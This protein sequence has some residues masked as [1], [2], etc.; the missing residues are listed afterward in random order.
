VAFLAI[1]LIPLCAAGSASAQ[2]APV[3]DAP[4]VPSHSRKAAPASPS[5]I[6]KSTTS[7]QISANLV[8]LD[9]VVRGA[10][11][12]PIRGLTG[13]DCAV[14][15]NGVHQQWEHFSAAGS[16][17]LTLGVLLDTSLSQ[18]SV[19]QVEERAADE[20]LRQVLQPH[21]EAF[22][23]S[24]DVDVTM[25]SDLTSNAK[26]LERAV[27]NAHINSY[28]GNYA[29]GTIPSI[30]KPKG[31]LLY[32][33]IILASD[34]KLGPAAGRKAIVLLTDG[35]DQGSRQSLKAAV[36]A[37]GRP[38]A[39]V[40]V[41]LIRNGDD[42]FGDSGER[43]MRTLAEAT[44]GHVFPIGNNTRKMK[45]AFQS[46]QQELHS[47]YQ[48]AYSPIDRLR[49]GTYRRIR[50]ECKQDGKQL[51]VQARQGYYAESDK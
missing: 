18:E 12:D 22:L 4:P 24:F 1:L 3:P 20:F 43:A 27:D 35:V 44:G 38:N 5:A 2:L 41:L 25:L 31:T 48:A 7:F 51:H 11:G 28:S 9:F 37:A 13:S 36:R 46:I 23:F 10:H 40:Y 39:V 49:D 45:A 8:T 30:G 34:D 50:I 33:A 16:P 17:P 32:D 21:D 19:L 47:Q 14:Y 42:L 26:N 15:E 6:P 29:V